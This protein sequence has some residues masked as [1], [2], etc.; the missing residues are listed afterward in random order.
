MRLAIALRP[1]V[2]IFTISTR[3]SCICWASTMSG[4]P[5]GMR[6]VTFGLPMSMVKWYRTFFLK[7]RA[8]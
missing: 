6:D 5:S 7:G 4:S 3:R 8:W 2:S 1:T